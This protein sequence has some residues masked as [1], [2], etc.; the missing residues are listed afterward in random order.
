MIYFLAFL[1][2]F[3]DIVSEIAQSIFNVAA[4][5]FYGIRNLLVLLTSL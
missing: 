5:R 1:R 2:C 3:L 4:S